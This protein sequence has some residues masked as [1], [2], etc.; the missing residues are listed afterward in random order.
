MRVRF[1]VPDDLVPKLQRALKA[2]KTRRTSSIIIKILRDWCFTRIDQAMA[3]DY[4]ANVLRYINKTEKNHD[5][6]NE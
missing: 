4:A 6:V 1:D 3:P 2:N 5:G